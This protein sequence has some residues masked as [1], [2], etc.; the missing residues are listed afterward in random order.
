[1]EKV[2]KTGYY[3]NS[4]KF[5]LLNVFKKLEPYREV[6]V[7]VHILFNNEEGRLLAGADLSRTESLK[8]VCEMFDMDDFTYI[9][10]HYIEPVEYKGIRVYEFKQN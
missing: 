2:Q 10:N 8:D 5:M 7:S 6:A 3:L 9:G 1:M 4:D